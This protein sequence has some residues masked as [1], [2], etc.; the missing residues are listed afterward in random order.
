MTKVKKNIFR[1]FK[2]NEI[3]SIEEFHY[4]YIIK[5]KI[6]T[7]VP[8]NFVDKLMYEMAFAGAGII[9]NY[10]ICSFRMKG[11]GTFKPS[12]KAK[13]Y[14]GTHGKL[15]FKEEVRLE[16]ECNTDKLDS[17]IDSLLN[18]HPY[19][20][21]A[22]EVYDFKKRKNEASGFIINFKK[23][24]NTADIMKRLNQKLEENVIDSKSKINK[25]AYIDSDLDK[26]ILNKV[27]INRCNY[28]LTFQ[29]KNKILI[30]I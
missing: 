17:V 22:Y 20:E 28:L 11:L 5:H 14:S 30:K 18:N 1:I 3:Q 7:F 29:N 15:S 19:E 10:E 26:N 16:M 25:L 27:I 4:D 6:V 21:A 13:P 24:L 9:G 12:S 8:L 23:D 2:S